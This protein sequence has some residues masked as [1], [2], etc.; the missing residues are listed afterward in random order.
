MGALHPKDPRGSID[1]G[2]E[3]VVH[4]TISPASPVA[5]TQAGA[6]VR[7]GGSSMASSRALAQRFF[8]QAGQQF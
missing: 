7:T 3:T 6:V 4:G 1:S 8:A 5:P 2:L